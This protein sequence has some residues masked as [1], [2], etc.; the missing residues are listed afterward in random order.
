MKNCV[1]SLKKLSVKEVRVIVKENG[2]T[3]LGDR[4]KEKVKITNV[5]VIVEIPLQVNFP[6]HVYCNATVIITA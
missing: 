3:I 4:G 6:N 5:T 1:E 2:E